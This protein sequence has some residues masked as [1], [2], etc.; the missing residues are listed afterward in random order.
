MGRSER[1]DGSRRGEEES[2]VGESLKW[3]VSGRERKE[4]EKVSGEK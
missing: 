2:R 1:E 4:L 3:V